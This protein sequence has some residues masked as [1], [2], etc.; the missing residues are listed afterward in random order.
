MVRPGF[1][2]YRHCNPFSNQGCVD[3]AEI[4]VPQ[5]AGDESTN[6]EQMIKVFP[7]P[8]AAGSELTVMLNM[9]TNE[10]LTI[11]LVHMSGKEVYLRDLKGSIPTS[12][13]TQGQK[14]FTMN[15][16]ML[17]PG[18]YL[19]RIIGNAHT[20]SITKIVITNNK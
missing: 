12:G 3:T 20:G 1:S 11:Q 9:N 10:D 16:D 14:K 2:D 15:P 4:F 8:L 7:N 18:I 17:S 19:L 13:V 5:L 6:V